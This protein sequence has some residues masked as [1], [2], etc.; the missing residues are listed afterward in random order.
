MMCEICCTRDLAGEAAKAAEKTLVLFAV[1]GTPGVTAAVDGIMKEHYSGDSID[2]DQAR[3]IQVEFEKRLKYYIA[4]GELTKKKEND[5]RWWN[6]A[7][8]VTGVVSEKD[9]R[10]WISPSK[11]APTT[12]KYPDK[13]LAAD[14]PLAQPGQKP[15]I[16]KINDR[17]SLKCIL[18]PA[19]K[20]FAG[21]PFYATYDGDGATM[22]TIRP[23]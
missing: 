4:P 3:K 13:M 15:L 14:K 5:A 23:Y 20:Y 8:A 6:P 10:K 16:I 9:G 18:L 7:K 22:T 17:L 21:V 19:G 11:I 1:E 12:L 2:G